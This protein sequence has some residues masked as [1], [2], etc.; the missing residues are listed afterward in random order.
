MSTRKSF[1][2]ANNAPPTK[3]KGRVDFGPAGEGVAA[4]YN[5]RSSFDSQNRKRGPSASMGSGA[6]FDGV[7]SYCVPTPSP[8]TRGILWPGRG[9]KTQCTTGIVCV[10]KDAPARVGKPS[11]ISTQFIQTKLLIDK[12]CAWILDPRPAQA[13]KGGWGWGCGRVCISVGDDVDTFV[14]IFC[15]LPRETT[16]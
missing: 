3:D 2:A 4:A 1:A 5:I 16:R 8:W 11:T 9:C 15:G 10:S 7:G 14:L 13:G 6:R 12:L